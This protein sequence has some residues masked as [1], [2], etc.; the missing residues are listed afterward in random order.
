M[1]GEL[2]KQKDAILK[3]KELQ[4]EME[5]FEEKSIQIQKDKLDLFVRQIESAG[6]YKAEAEKEA[7]KEIAKDPSAYTEESKRNV[8]YVKYQRKIG[9]DEKIAT[10]I[11]KRIITECLYDKPIFKNPFAV[12]PIDTGNNP[13]G[14]PDATPEQ[15]KQIAEQEAAEAEKEELAKKEAKVE[16]EPAQTQTE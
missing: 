5:E 4:K 12:E 3:A 15:E 13:E 6:T 16:K 2:L 11:C 1:E 9:T 14:T 10:R 7:E 8:K